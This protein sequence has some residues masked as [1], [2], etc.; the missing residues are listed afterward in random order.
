MTALAGTDVCLKGYGLAADQPAQDPAPTPDRVS[1]PAPAPAPA[2]ATPAAPAVSVRRRRGAAPLGA[3][4]FRVSGPDATSPP[5]SASRCGPVRARSSG[6]GRCTAWHRDRATP[7]A[8]APRRT[9]AVRGGGG[10]HPRHRTGVEDGD[11]HLARS[12]NPRR[13]LDGQLSRR[14]LL[15]RVAGDV[16]DVDLEEVAPFLSLFF[17]T[18]L[19]LAFVLTVPVR[20]LMVSTFLPP[21]V[22]TTILLTV[23][24]PQ[25]GWA[26]LTLNFSCQ[27]PLL[28]LGRERLDRPAEPCRCR[29]RPGRR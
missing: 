5:T 21:A 10:R 19:T 18:S 3:R 4:R 12:L 8:C 27:L 24:A 9:R 20:P 23:A 17:T 29:P 16:G 25:P 14:R 11:R 2:P 22:V 1:T 15:A 26:S 13:L 6:G 7:G 28:A